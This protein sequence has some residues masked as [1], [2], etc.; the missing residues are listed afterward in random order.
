MFNGLARYQG[1]K[2]ANSHGEDDVQNLA[3]QVH[4]MGHHVRR[5]ILEQAKD[6]VGKEVDSAETDNWQLP[7][8]QE[9]INAQAEAAMRDLFPRIPNFDKQMIL[10]HAFKK[11][12]PQSSTSA[13]FDRRLT[14][15]AMQGEG[16]YGKPLVGTSDLPLYRRVQLAVLAHI[17]HV[18]TRYDHILREVE[19]KVARKAVEKQC[20]DILVKWRGD[21]ETGRDQLGDILREVVVISDADDDSASEGSED[22]DE[23]SDDDSV[24]QDNYAVPV[25]TVPEPM[26]ISPTKNTLLSSRRRKGKARAR[27]NRISKAPQA[28]HSKKNSGPNKDKRGFNRYEAAQAHEITRNQRWE[29]ALNRNRHAQNTEAPSLAPVQRPPSQNVLR[30]PSVEI[31]SP[32]HR[33]DPMRDDRMRPASQPF[34]GGGQGYAQHVRPGGVF[35]ANFHRQGRPDSLLPRPDSGFDSSEGV[36]I[37]RRVGPPLPDPRNGPS[38][39]PMY[40][41]ELKDFLVPSVEPISPHSRVDEPRSIRRVIRAEPM[42]SEQVPTGQIGVTRQVAHLERRPMGMAPHDHPPDQGFQ[43][44]MGPTNG[45]RILPRYASHYERDVRPPLN[46]VPQDSNRMYRIRE[47]FLDA[48][49]S[50]EVVAA[51]T[52]HVVRVHREARPTEFWEPES[53]RVRE[54]SPHRHEANGGDTPST[55]Y[56]SP[57]HQRIVYKE[58]S[59]SRFGA[60]PQG[61][62][63]SLPR[64]LYYEVHPPQQRDPWQGSI[65][66]RSQYTSVPQPQAPGFRLE[67]PTRPT[68]YGEPGSIPRNPIEYQHR[69]RVD[70]F[71]C[72]VNAFG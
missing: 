24:V 26:D 40:H 7:E 12:G 30:H 14:I 29:E 41:G 38:S 18:H 60:H 71:K 21:E 4:R 45:E 69:G 19:W 57:A 33:I 65:S 55:A 50:P 67:A 37:G 17:R 6:Q 42:R 62:I 44:A 32:V 5:T 8:T 22:E 66:E 28:G 49:Y 72:P 20:L 1:A 16:R 68:F 54:L 31:V 11:V 52:T 23:S 47:P 10:E 48:R 53:A 56:E 13:D 2:D 39:G 27:F 51:G 61:Q 34:Y 25:S 3:L 43:P 58:A 70:L 36:V 63:P 15:F 64:P 35:T 9:E 59:A 46:I